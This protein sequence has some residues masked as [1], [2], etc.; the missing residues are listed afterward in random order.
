M[1]NTNHGA[2]A[3]AGS[4]DSL[5]RQLAAGGFTVPPVTPL[6]ELYASYVRFTEEREVPTM[7][8]EEFLARLATRWV[9]CRLS[10][11]RVALLGLALRRGAS[12]GTAQ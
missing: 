9:P 3:A 7:P 12:W 10:D 5:I 8:V 6:D 2:S 4:Q 1:T 11:G